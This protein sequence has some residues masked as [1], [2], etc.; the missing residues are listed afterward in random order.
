M[1]GS[2]PLKKRT[3]RARCHSVSSPY[4]DTVRRQLSRSQE[5]G[6]PQPPTVLTP[7]SGTHPQAGALGEIDTCGEAAQPVGLC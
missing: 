6:C 5:E 7:P 1:V 3:E 2:L 4:Q